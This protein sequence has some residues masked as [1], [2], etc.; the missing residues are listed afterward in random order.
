M[1]SAVI[2]LYTKFTNFGGAQKIA[3]VLYQDLLSDRQ[4]FLMGLTKYYD[5]NEKYPKVLE[6]FYLSFSMR[7]ILKHRDSVFV[8]HHRQI[9]TLL[10]IIKKLFFLDLRIIH[11]SHNEFYTLKFLTLFPEK[12]I[13]VSNKVKLNLQSYFNVENHRIHIIYNGVADRLRRGEVNTYDSGRIRIL[14]PARVNSVKQQVAI[15][16]KIKGV[17]CNSV[18]IDFAGEGE[19]SKELNKACDGTTQFNYIGFVSIDQVIHNYDFVML[20]TRNEGLPLSLIEACM[21]KKPIIANDVGGNLEIL[22]NGYN[23]FVLSSFESLAAELNE[24]QKVSKA[25]Y[26]ELAI[27][28]R[29]TYMDHFTIDKMILNYRGIIDGL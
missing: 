28:A 2:N 13:A 15:V 19:D 29:K 9:T 3:M 27:N 24:L 10:V 7:N 1:K 18:S 4:S 12:I 5:I 22:K 6:T 8:S 16:E 23:G 17:L 26:S 14:Y 25:E 11:V 20:F 21:F